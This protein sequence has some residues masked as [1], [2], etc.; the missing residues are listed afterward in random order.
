MA[1]QLITKTPIFA[2]KEEAAKGNGLTAED[3][4]AAVENLTATQAWDVTQASAAA[5][6]YL[7]GTARTWFEDV[8]TLSNPVGQAAARASF[9]DFKRLF[10]REYYGLKSTFDLAVD[11]HNLKQAEKEAVATFS[12]CLR[13]CQST[14]RSNVDLRP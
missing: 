4:I 6:S 13:L 9:V 1:T 7:N 2:G 12:A 11:W 8:L 14:A 3:F 10:V 5:I